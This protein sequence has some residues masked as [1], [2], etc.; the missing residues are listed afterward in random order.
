[1]YEIEIS[2]ELVE[3]VLDFKISHLYI[4][5][6]I[7]SFRKKVQIWDDITKYYRYDDEDE[8]CEISIYEFSFK[9]KKWALEQDFALNSGISD[10][11]AKVKFAVITNNCHNSYK[12]FNS[13][14]EQQA[15]FDACQWILENK[16]EE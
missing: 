15:V 5:E 16:E 3:T 6:D 8:E 12:T 7:I 1:M 10:H 2:K 4:D 13:D 14:T 11:I 9:C